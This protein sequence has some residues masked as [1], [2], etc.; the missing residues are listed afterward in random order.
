MS[1]TQPKKPRKGPKKQQP[2][3]AAAPAAAEP[4][5]APGKP[6]RNLR[7]SANQFLTDISHVL[8]TRGKKLGDLMAIEKELQNFLN[9]GHPILSEPVE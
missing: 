3:V 9:I 8:Y 6:A 4:A 2:E 5:P 1:D 7:D